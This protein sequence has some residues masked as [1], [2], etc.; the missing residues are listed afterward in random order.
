MTG[1]MIFPH[2]LPAIVHTYGNPLNY[3]DDKR[4]WETK[5][6]LTRPLPCALP[7]AYAR[8]V[9]VAR[10]TA[11]RLIVDRFVEALAACLSRGVPP[12]RLVYGGCYSWRAQRG[13]SKLSLHTWGIAIDLCPAT[14][15]WRTAWDALDPATRL[16]P[17]IIE[18]FESL[19][20]T[21]GGRWASAPDPMH[22]QAASGY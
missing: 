9:E 20:F 21:W 18:V 22:F 5:T 4:A 6:L 17:T 15:P 19:G 12:E 1:P 8:E 3:L 11:H 13:A 10:I 7:Y 16:H 14:N 2:G